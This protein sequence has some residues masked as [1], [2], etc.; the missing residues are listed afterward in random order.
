MLNQKEVI[1]EI[2]QQFNE[3]VKEFFGLDE[4]KLKYDPYVRFYP[5]G[6]EIPNR[7]KDSLDDFKEI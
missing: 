5:L 6:E 1:Q 7:I 4:V 3:Q 2:I